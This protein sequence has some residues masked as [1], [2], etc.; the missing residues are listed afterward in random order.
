MVCWV[1]VAAAVSTKRYTVPVPVAAGS[2]M[3]IGVV[4]AIITVRLPCR[5]CVKVSAVAPAV[6]WTA[7]PLP[8]SISEPSA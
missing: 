1:A 4:E 8:D 5:A 6:L 7:A 3:A 2:V